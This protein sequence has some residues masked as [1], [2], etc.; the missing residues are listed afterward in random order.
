MMMCGISNVQKSDFLGEIGNN[1]LLKERMDMLDIPRV[2]RQVARLASEVSQE[3][4][5]EP[6][7]YCSG[8]RM[9]VA[10]CLQ[11]YFVCFS[12]KFGAVIQKAIRFIGF[13]LPRVFKTRI[14]RLTI[15]IVNYG[16]NIVPCVKRC[17]H[18]L[19][20]NL[21]Q[22]LQQHPPHQLWERCGDCIFSRVLSITQQRQDLSI[23][24]IRIPDDCHFSK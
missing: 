4:V 19:N 21:K 6:D 10:R 2:S 18:N 24:Y 12:I 11:V 16:C 23:Y 15:N 20:K 17:N 22:K 8:D 5:G 7:Q 1:L 9:I 14:A 3:W 13:H